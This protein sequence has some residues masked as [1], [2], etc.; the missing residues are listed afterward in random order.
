MP[1]FS[2]SEKKAIIN[3][4]KTKYQYQSDTEFKSYVEVIAGLR[5]INK[6]LGSEWYQRAADEM[7]G[8]EKSSLQDH[9]VRY[10]LKMDEPKK[11]V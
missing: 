6:I 2:E 8:S 4:V 3:E 1:V 7:E 9:P 5:I 11:I 10:Y